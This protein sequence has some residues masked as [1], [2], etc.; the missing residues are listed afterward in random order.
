MIIKGAIANKGVAIGKV[1]IIKNVNDFKKFN[2]NDILVAKLTDPS[3][4]TI[5]IKASAIITDQGGITSHPAI[6]SR[7]FNLPCI[8]G[9]GNATQVLKDGDMV[10]VDADK[11]VVKIL[12]R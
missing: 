7:E 5:I 3:Y 9:A 12:K 4:V 11:G 1:K 2:E 6:I 10:E 8:V